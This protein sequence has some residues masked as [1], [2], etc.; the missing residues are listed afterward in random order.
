[1]TD[2]DGQYT[3]SDRSIV[4]QFVPEPLAERHLHQRFPV[5]APPNLTLGMVE[6][7]EA[8]ERAD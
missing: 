2:P 3:R 5:F 8:V 7:G 1:V 6:G 4:P